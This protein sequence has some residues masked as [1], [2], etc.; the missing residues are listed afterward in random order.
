MENFRNPNF[1]LIADVLYWMVR[2][3]DPDI[4][5]HQDIETEDDRVEFLQG[6]S[7]A[8]ASRASIKLNTKRLYAAD[9]NAVQELVSGNG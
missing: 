9:G 6:I 4:N 7:Q 2:K 3:Y 5:C 8:M 1:E